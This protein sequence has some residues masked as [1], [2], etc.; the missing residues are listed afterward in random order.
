MYHIHEYLK[1]MFFNRIQSLRFLIKNST[2]IVA[3]ANMQFN[4]NAS[5]SIRIYIIFQY[6]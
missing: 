1:F 6:D 5:H 3:N 4:L 2:K